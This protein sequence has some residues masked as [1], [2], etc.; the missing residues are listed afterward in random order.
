MTTSTS[1][2]ERTGAYR[3]SARNYLLD[4]RFQLKYSGFLV[5]VA[6]VI[7]GIMGAVLYETTRAVVTESAA[8]V[9]ESKKV[10]E[11]SRMNVR[12]LAS[13]SPE[14][15]TEFNREADAH[16]KVLA[17]QQASLIR[18]Q[19]WM[20]ESLVG[21]LALMVVLIGLLGI[22]FTHKVAGPVYKMKRL[23]KQVGEGNLHVD[24]RLRKGDE[25]QDFFEAFAQMVA[26]L[27]ASEARQLKDVD[28][29]HAALESGSRGRR[30]CGAAS[31]ARRHEGGSWDDDVV[32]AGAAAARRSADH[33]LD[34]LDPGASPRE[35]DGGR[36]DPDARNIGHGVESS[37][38]QP[39]DCTNEPS[40]LRPGDALEGPYESSV[41][42]R[43]DLRDDHQVALAS[44]HVQFEGTEPHVPAQDRE[45]VG[46]EKIGDD[47]LGGQAELS[48]TWRQCPVT[49]CAV[50]QSPLAGLHVVQTWFGLYCVPFL[51]QYAP[52]SP[53]S[54][55][56]MEL[57]SCVQLNPSGH[58][59]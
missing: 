49:P 43:S 13:D 29:A 41:S 6:I 34:V 18:R 48:T 59:Q 53:E 9:D 56:P 14:L 3:R 52:V 58:L 45:A 55:T 44:D 37:S 10:S 16:D 25:L 35:R 28:E 8:L 26:S 5:S 22:Y 32:A 36:V 20:I 19:R 30:G 23:L 47:E 1:P 2:P 39:A 27:R 12:D 57:T 11:V 17:D 40:A 54:V 51:M 21:G 15:M 38:P 31:G 50:P 7:S 42:A 4:S 24:A 33:S 46:E